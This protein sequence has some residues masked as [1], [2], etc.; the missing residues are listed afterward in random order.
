MTRPASLFLPLPVGPLFIWLHRLSF[1]FHIN[2]TLASTWTLP[3][4]KTIQYGEWMQQNHSVVSPPRPVLFPNPS[5]C[6]PHLQVCGWIPNP[7]GKTLQAHWVIIFSITCID[8]NL[9]S[10]I[11]LQKSSI[12]RIATGIG[13]PLGQ[14]ANRICGFQSFPKRIDQM[15]NKSRVFWSRS[16]NVYTLHVSRNVEHARRW[17]SSENAQE[18]QHIKV[19][20][21]RRFCR[22]KLQII[23]AHKNKNKGTNHQRKRKMSTNDSPFPS[24]TSACW[25]TSW[26]DQ[27]HRPLAIRTSSTHI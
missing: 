18:P 21:L 17:G 26:E 15:Q 20:S 5:V 22:C 9:S 23:A 7:W 6:P 12:T 25:Q 3:F 16:L 1:N 24:K 14:P 11:Y 13:M 10:N 4:P 27:L 19:N 2:C 8:C